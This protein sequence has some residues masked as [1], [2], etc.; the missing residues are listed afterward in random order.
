MSP[1]FSAESPHPSHTRSD[2]AASDSWTTKHG[3]LVSRVAPS[4]SSPNFYACLQVNLLANLSAESSPPSTLTP[5]KMG[6]GS[7]NKTACAGAAD[8][9][10]LSR[11]RV[12]ARVT[13]CWRESQGRACA[14]RKGSDKK[15]LQ[16]G[17]PHARH[18]SQAR[19]PLTP[20]LPVACLL[21]GAQAAPQ[22]SR[23]TMVPRRTTSRCVPA[24]MSL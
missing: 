12:R 19:G 11:A 2:M 6:G 13:H 23:D 15:R 17:L 22:S 18:A 20:R 24:A 7:N 14:S 8:S 5:P 16:V 3:W 9:G 1:A 21:A 10:R 4:A